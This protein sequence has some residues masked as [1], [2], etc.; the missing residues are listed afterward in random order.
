MCKSTCSAYMLLHWNFLFPRVTEPVGEWSTGASIARTLVNP[1]VSQVLCKAKPG[2]KRS[3]LRVIQ[4]RYII[5]SATVNM[6]PVSL[7]HR[8]RPCSFSLGGQNTQISPT[9]LG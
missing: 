9:P 5:M 6:F 4:G 8:R 1:A 3:G 2:N 7:S